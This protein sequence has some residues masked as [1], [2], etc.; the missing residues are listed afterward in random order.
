MKRTL[1]ISVNAIGDAYLT[2]SAISAIQEY[3]NNRDSE[4]HFACSDKAEFLVKD[5]GVSKIFTIGSKNIFSVMNLLL[6]LREYEYDI[7]LCP[8]PGR[9]NSFLY[10]LCKGIKKAGFINFKKT[11]SWDDKAALLN[12]NNSETDHEWRPGENFLKRVELCLVGVGIR[13]EKKLIKLQ[14]PKLEEMN[15]KENSYALLH[16]NSRIPQK[17]I[18]PEFVEFVIYK[19]T[20]HGLNIKL[21]DAP[22]FFTKESKNVEYLKTASL[23]Q[24]VNLIKFSNFFLGVDSFPMHLADAYNKKIIGFFKLSNPLSVLSDQV[25]KFPIDMNQDKPKILQDIESII[26]TQFI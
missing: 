16:F 13:S 3:F 26:N 12:V 23:G 11:L 18:A 5:L 4:I 2:A 24:L 17:N 10:S 19:L 22:E 8:F 1:L 14:F 25:D 7:V 20:L 9:I 15:S 21:L 6:N